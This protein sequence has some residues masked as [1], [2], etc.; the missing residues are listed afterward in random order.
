[1]DGALSFSIADDVCFHIHIYMLGAD[2]VTGEG[3]AYNLPVI[4]LTLSIA[5]AV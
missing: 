4:C 2:E 5:C 1:M 3:V